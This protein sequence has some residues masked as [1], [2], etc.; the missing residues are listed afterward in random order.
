MLRLWLSKL[1]WLTEQDKSL[2]SEEL[3][4]KLAAVSSK[5]ESSL[6]EDVMARRMACI[7]G[8]YH[9]SFFGEDPCCE[10]LY[11]KYLTQIELLQ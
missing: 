4:A 1:G 9:G 8:G 7:R 5:Y 2:S 6:M 10:A 11:S 3:R